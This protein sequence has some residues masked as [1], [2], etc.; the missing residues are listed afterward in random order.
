V[1]DTIANWI[2]AIATALALVAATWAG[3]TARKLYSIEQRRLSRV[4]PASI[5]SSAL[6]PFH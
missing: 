1:A 6:S 3:L 5:K 4:A 2:T